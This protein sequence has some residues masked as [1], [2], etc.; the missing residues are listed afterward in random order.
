M[1]TSKKINA[2]LHFSWIHQGCALCIQTL[3]CTHVHAN[4][5]H[6]DMYWSFLAE[7][8]KSWQQTSSTLYF[9][10]HPLK[11]GTLYTNT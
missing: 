5:A 8:L 11:T 9:S 3:V 4:C 10:V 2:H 6:V 1:I 7:P